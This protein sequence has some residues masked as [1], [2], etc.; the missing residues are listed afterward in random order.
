MRKR[1]GILLLLTGIGIGLF[2]YNYWS[3]SCGR[4]N[5]ES[6]LT[7]SFPAEI[8]IVM[9]LVALTVLALVKFRQRNSPDR[10]QCVCGARLHPDWQF[11]PDCGNPQI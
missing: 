5:T 7:L 11:C 3:Y 9:N 8:L 2:A 10:F 1:Y 4:C 6:L